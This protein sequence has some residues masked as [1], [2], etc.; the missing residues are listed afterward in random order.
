VERERGEDGKD[1]E[2]RR[3]EGKGREDLFQIAG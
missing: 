2:G 1:W 3:G